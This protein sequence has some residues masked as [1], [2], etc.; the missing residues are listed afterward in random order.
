METDKGVKYRQ[1]AAD[2][3]EAAQTVNNYRI[4]QN[5]ISIAQSWQKMAQQIEQRT[6]TLAPSQRKQPDMGHGR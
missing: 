2:C 4:R 3:L 1:H 6:Q 5:L